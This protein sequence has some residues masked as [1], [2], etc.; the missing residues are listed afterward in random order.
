MTNPY[1]F[2]FSAEVQQQHEALQQT[3]RDAVRK[4]DLKTVTSAQEKLC[5]WLQTHPD[6]Y[7]MW[8]AGEPLALLADAL[9]A[10]TAQPEPAHAA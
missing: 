8:D 2:V 7:V 3:L 5:V 6:D 4:G 1:T 9:E 10:E